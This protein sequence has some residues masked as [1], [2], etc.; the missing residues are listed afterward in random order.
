[1][2]RSR[3]VPVST[4]CAGRPPRALAALLA[5]AGVV[6]AVAIATADAGEG[7]QRNFAGSVQ[8][9]YMAVPTESIARRQ[10]LD[11]ATVELSLKLAMDYGDHVSSNIKVCVA[12]HGLEVGMAFF[13]L[14]VAD[15]LNFRVGRFTPAF[16][17]FP[18]RHD[19]ANHRTS[20][21]PL[22]YDMG[23]MLRIQEWNMSVLPAPWVDNGIEIN[24]THFF[25]DTLQVDYAAYAIGGPRASVDAVDFDFRQS[26]SPESY[27]VDNNS[28]PVVGAHLAWSIHTAHAVLLAGASAMAGTYDPDD[29]LDFALMGAHAVLR[30]RGL[31]LRAEY[32]ARRTRMSLGDDPASRF[33][34]GPGKDGRFDPYF[35]KEG[36]YGELEV[37]AGRFDFVLRWDGMRRRGN[38]IRTSELR[39]DSAVLRYTVGATYQLREALRLKVSGELYD[40]TDF[41]DEA[42]VHLGIAGPF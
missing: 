27:Y 30:V 15:E 6:G 9:D 7:L 2:I 28:R 31:F 8:L 29:E 22:P 11:G 13:D 23:R 36:F 38:V 26:R 18:L 25:G 39:S 17:E 5:G 42:V 32:L 20:D 24:G 34:Y 12:C 35:L 3:P 4:P 40:F 21:K 41:E 1:V 37:P 33:R 19:P 14:R 16:G 10:A